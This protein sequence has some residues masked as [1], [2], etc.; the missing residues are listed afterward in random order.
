ME[1]INS[2]RRISRSNDIRCKHLFWIIIAGLFLLLLFYEVIDKVRLPKK[3]LVDLYGVDKKSFNKWVNHFC[4]DIIPDM[5]AYKRRRTVSLYEYI[6]IVCHFGKPS[7]YPILTKKEIVEKGDG[8]YYSLRE[9]IKRHPLFFGLP[10]YEAFRN[11]QK[12]PPKI[13]K[14]IME[15]YS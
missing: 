3:L 7:H 9:C 2:T 13:S 8:T 12:F 1:E 10:S 14:R 11:M 6:L 5:D 4:K 15:Q